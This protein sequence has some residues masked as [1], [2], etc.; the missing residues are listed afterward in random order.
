MRGCLSALRKDCSCSNFY[1]NNFPK[2]E[3]KIH[4]RYWDILKPSSFQL[5]PDFDAIWSPFIGVRSVRQVG[6]KRQFANVNPK[7][8]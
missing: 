2:L 8:V 5:E 6:L 3:E 4:C 7:V 1:H